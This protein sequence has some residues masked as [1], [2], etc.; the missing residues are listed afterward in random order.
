MRVEIVP[1][2]LLE[3]VELA[4][5]PV[6]EWKRTKQGKRVV[7]LTQRGTEIVNEGGRQRYRV[8]IGL[9]VVRCLEGSAADDLVDHILGVV[10]ADRLELRGRLAIRQD[11]V[12]DRHA[13][14][15]P[16]YRDPDQRDRQNDDDRNG[17]NK[18][19]RQADVRS[20][21]GCVSSWHRDD[22]RL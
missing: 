4:V 21:C 20:R 22:S 2:A 16:G 5:A 3:V 12:V 15:D 1:G 14:N 6:R 10:G 8:R 17:K 18:P 19:P 11:G 7:V 9:V 13:G